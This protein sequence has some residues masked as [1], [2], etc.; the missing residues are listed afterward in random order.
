MSIQP[1]QTDSTRTLPL[2]RTHSERAKVFS[3]RKFVFFILAFFVAPLTFAYASI[4]SLFSDIFVKVATEVRPVNSQNLA[5]LTAS[6]GASGEAGAAHLSEV[7]TVA[8]SALLPD[9]GPSGGPAEIEGTSDHG[10]I[11]LYIVKEG[12]SLSRIAQT[13]GVSVNTILWA[14]DLPRGAKITV[15]QALLI[16]PVSGVQHEVKKGDTL[17]SIAKKYR[18]D[19]EEIRAF[20][21]LAE[22]DLLVPGTV[23][24]IPDGEIATVVPVQKPASSKLASAPTTIDDA[25][26]IAPLQNYR[27]TQKLHGYN[28][29]DMASYLGA[30]VLA[31]AGGSVI[32]ARSGG[33][34]GGY[35]SYVVV[36]HGNGTQTLYA[37]LQSV[38]VGVGESVFQGQSVGTMGNTGRSTGPHLHFE[39][40]GARNPFAY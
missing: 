33:Y 14:N 1:L 26:F 32:V 20:N 2:E 6:V 9:V 34:N 10:E 35:G 31:S 28:A 7:N 30:P 37:H 11:S 29:V 39:V 19:E 4:F 36:K 27:R 25:Y 12:D 38:A 5:L 18:G 40:R 22:N 13:F 16:L 24:I 3:V 15:G 17:S 21:G 8:G 23:I